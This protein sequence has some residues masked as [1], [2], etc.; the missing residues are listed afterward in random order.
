[1]IKVDAAL[2]PLAEA[3]QSLLAA[4]KESQSKALLG[5]SVDYQAV[6]AL[7]TAATGELERA[8]HE[9]ILRSMIPTSDRIEV[10]GKTYSRVAV[11]LGCYR[12]MSGPVSFE[13]PLYREVGIRNGKVVD[14]IALRVGAIGEGWLPSTAR[15]MSY[16][17]Q[18]GTSREAAATAKELGRLPYSRS[19]FE[20]V[21]HQLASLFDPHQAKIE[22]ELITELTLPKETESI[23]ASIDRVSIP[24][25]EAVM[26]PVGRPRKNAA[27]RPI[28]RN[29]RMAYCASLTMHD[30]DG[31]AL[32]T[33]RY[34][35]MP[36][37]DAVGLAEALASDTMA[38]LKKKPGLKVALLADGAPEM[39]DLLEGQL[40]E[41]TLGERPTSL[42]DFWHF[43]E[44]IAAAAKVI[45][46]E[47][48]KQELRRWLK[49]LRTKRSA[50]LRILEELGDSG[51]EHTTVG[52][53]R[54]VH[55]AITYIE[56]H[57]DR[58]NYSTALNKKLPIGSGNVE[59]TC[60]SLVAMRMKRSGSRWKEDSGH[61]V[62]QFRALALSSRWHPAMDKLFERIRTPVRR[63]A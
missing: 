59:A 63:A 21:P 23:S 1:M 18:S 39:W 9:S 54:P 27:K 45:Y 52:K 43:A 56:N 25:E 7:V 46:G 5:C 36:K 15:A 13:R 17:L 62:M 6:E 22:E 3:F 11:K 41:S 10:R 30:G 34:G 4:V 33:I 35:C 42:V 55:D 61:Q 26:R 19:S 38:I 58:M 12:S 24:M 50:C 37:G 32:Y 49:N 57:K 60:K 14:P 48:S 2:K 8:G 29:Y 20:R 47:D 31:D 44:K 53:T 51:M 16:L 28:Q 40:N